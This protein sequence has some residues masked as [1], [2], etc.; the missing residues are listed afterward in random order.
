MGSSVFAEQPIFPLSHLKE[1]SPFQ[2][3]V[4]VLKVRQKKS[5][6]MYNIFH[7]VRVENVIRGEGVAVGDELLVCSK[8]IH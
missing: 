4:T 1:K 8:K 2:L 5:E 3:D 7:K 6:G